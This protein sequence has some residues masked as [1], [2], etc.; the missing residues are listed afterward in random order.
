MTTQSTPLLPPTLLNVG[1]RYLFRHPLQSLLLILG[2]TLGVAVVVAIDIANASA[3]RAFDLST[4]S[5]AGRT[6]HQIVG[7]PQGFDTSLYRELRQAGLDLPLAPVVTDFFTSPQLGDRPITLLGIDPFTEAPFRSY[8]GGSTF[9]AAGLVEF[10]TQPGAILISTDVAA[11]YDLSVGQQIDIEI[12]GYTRT[13]TIA[14][15]L[16]PADELSR[17]ALDNLVF[18]DIATVQ[19][20]TGRDTLD[21][22]DL[23]LDADPATAAQQAEQV[24]ALLPA[25]VR[26]QPVEA[27]SGAIQQ[28]TAAFRTNLTALSLLALI[29]GMFLI[30]NTMTFSVV[31]RR[32]LFGTLRCLGVTRREI[33]LMV[34]SEAL[35]VGTVGGI[36][37]LVLGV[38]LGQ[39][40]VRLVTQTINDLFFALSVRGVQIPLD[41]LL[42]GGALG[43]I[44]TVITAALPAWEA[45]SIPPRAALSRAGLESTARVAVNRVAIGGILA[46]LAGAAILLIPTRDLVIS[47]AGTFAAIIGFAMLAPIA[48]VAFMRLVAP[49]TGRGFGVLGRMAP[50]S[51]TNALSRTSIAVAALM[52]AVSVTIGVSLMISSFRYTVITWLD[53]TLVGDIYISAPSATANSATTAVDPAVITEL[54]AWPGVTEVTLLR[55]AVVDSPAGAAQLTAVTQP[56][57]DPDLFLTADASPAEVWEMMQQGAVI[58]SEPFANRREL[59]LQGA[60]IDLF[61]GGELRTFPVVGVFYSYGSPEGFIMMALPVYQDLFNDDAISAVSLTV[62]PGIDP[63]E[64]TAD[65]QDALI[66][67]QQLFIRDNLSL[68]TEALLVFDRTFA[69][70]GAMQILATVVAFIG[71]LSALLALQLEKQR[72]LGIMRAVGLTRRQLWGLTLLET[73]L[74]G[75]VAGL[76]AMPTG[77]ALSLILVFII[78]KRSFGWTL[79]LQNDPAPF[80]AALLIAVVAALLAG[81]YPARRLGQMAAAD[82]IRFE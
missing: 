6:T 30:Y 32:P 37:G 53:Q 13:A 60:T 14:G 70:T 67:L 33:F 41:S 52:V 69:I 31:Q 1:W 35:L 17:R 4:D 81:I 5:I 15:L 71:V 20:L 28:M 56:P 75:I 23:I 46:I 2:I 44:A 82:A 77:F 66:P 63:R 27:R 42:K 50:R 3:S 9:Q 51:V 24:A 34:V 57:L 78:N 80:I 11:R 59:P 72:E 58:I 73:G 47:F 43:L 29:V 18:A 19:E 76:L 7:P 61:V 39:G 55:A 68:R 16:D 45:A 22:I 74:M 54:E 10:F 49:L 64:T 36:L 8:L 25:T 12:G 38:I 62:A 21:R 26:L 65:L 40:A 79:Q 48:T